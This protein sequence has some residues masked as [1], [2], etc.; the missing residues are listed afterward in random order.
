[1]YLQGP[2]SGTGGFTT[3]GPGGVVLYAAGKTYTGPVTNSVGSTL[4]LFT[5]AVAVPGSLVVAGT[6]Y[7]IGDNQ[8][9]LTSGLMILHSGVYH[10]GSNTGSCDTLSGSGTLDL[11]TIV[12][13]VG[14]S[15]L[16]CQ[17]DGVITNTGKLMVKSCTLTLTGNNSYTGT[18]EIEGTLFVNGYQPQSPVLL[19]MFGALSGTGRVGDVTASDATIQPGNPVGVLTSGN[20]VFDNGA[21]LNSLLFGSTALTSY[22]Q[23]NTAYATNVDLTGGILNV[24]PFFNA[25]DGPTNGQQ[26]IIINNPTPYPIVGT[27]SGLPNGTIFT[28]GYGMQ[29]RIGY[30]EGGFHN[31]VLTYTNPPSQSVVMAVKS[32]TGDGS[33][34]PN[35]C[36]SISLTLRNPGGTPMTNVSAVLKSLTPGAV[37]SQPFSAYPNIPAGGS[38][39]NLTPFQILTYYYLPCSG[40]VALE[41]TFQTANLGTFS[42]PFMFQSGAP[43][44][45][46]NLTPLTIPDLTTVTSSIPVSGLL[47]PITKVEVLMN[48]THS[49]DADLV[50]DLIA[51]DGTLVNLINHNGMNGQNF[52]SACGS[53]FTETIFDDSAAASIASGTAPFLGNY[54]PMSGLFAYVG[55]SGTNVNNAK[56]HLRV[57]DT[58]AGNSGTLQCWS[59]RIWP[60]NCVD[61]GGACQL[62]PNT[63]LYGALGP[64]SPT[65]SDRLTRNGTPTTCAAPTGCPGGF[66][67]ESDYYDFY[68]FRNGP[69]DACITVTLTAPNA[70]L[71]SA[72]YT[73]TF[74]PSI[75]CSNYLADCGDSTLNNAAP[76]YRTY[77]FS[78]PAN[79]VFIVTVNGIG[80][81]YGPY[82]LSV[83]GGSCQPTL[84]IKQVGNNQ[85]KLA[86]PTSAGGYLLEGANRVGNPPIWQPVTNPAVEIGGQFVV[87]NA[88]GSNQFYRLRKPLH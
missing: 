6:T 88:I 49:Y 17:F 42:V 10:V 74:N 80:G 52:G 69:S 27:F 58:D 37:V 22:G 18:T 56:W 78:A 13:N 66:G 51:P 34:N 41:A 46:D 8:L 82:S 61:G 7:Q 68:I 15:G 65:Q 4:Y 5:S 35:G 71:F 64:S 84:N 75:V 24:F 60:D 43:L 29:F 38:A 3:I 20:V 76:G 33:L 57:A 86:W 55:K 2:V 70:D 73:N 50:V 85:V 81:G 11:G 1:M 36:N 87:T 45:F 28:A 23:L 72:A 9:G 67:G 44:Q 30:N 31:V 16:Q 48:F 25:D 63:V 53:D 47:A 59:L 54:R 32:G 79:G 26:Y 39:T 83:S 40:P 14:H 62:C 19:D 21:A 12:M 77:S